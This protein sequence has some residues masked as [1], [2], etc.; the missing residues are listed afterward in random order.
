MNLHFLKV[1]KGNDRVKAFHERFGAKIIS[2]NSFLILKK[3]IIKYKM[4]QFLDLID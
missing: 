1:Q 4:I 2:E 3:K